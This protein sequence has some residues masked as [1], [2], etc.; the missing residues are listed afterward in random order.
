MQASRFI[1]NETPSYLVE[2]SLWVGETD[3]QLN[4]KE[5]YGSWIMEMRRAVFSRWLDRV[6]TSPCFYL[7]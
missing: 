5:D 3:C 6:F 7:H 2:K 4:H 1:S